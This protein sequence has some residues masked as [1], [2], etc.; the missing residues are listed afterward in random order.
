MRNGSGLAEGASPNLFEPVR[1]NFRFEIPPAILERLSDLAGIPA[2]YRP[3]F[4]NSIIELFA[5]AHRWHRM[6][7]RSVEMDAAAKELNRIAKE[8]GKLKKN[9]DKLSP[10]A[11]MTLGLYALRL[12]QFGEAES[13]EAVRN[14]IEALLQAGSSGQAIPKVDYLSWAVGR[15]GSAA[16]TKTWSKRQNGNPAPWQGADS[17]KNPHIDT[18]NRFIVELREAV[19]AC[20]GAPG[21]EQYDISDGLRAFLKAASSCLPDGFIPNEVLYPAENGSHAAVSRRKGLMSFW[22]RKDARRRLSR[23]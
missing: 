19:R 21:F 4:A 5:K 20:N 8:A 11:R 6:A 1:E 12:D 9:I 14:Q 3:T 16:A 18:F 2:H 22:L 23:A 13:D 15:I 17:S 10:Q 7:N